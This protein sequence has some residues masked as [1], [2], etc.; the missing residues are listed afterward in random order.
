MTS[1]ERGGEMTPL[2]ELSGRDAVEN[3]L[4]FI[5]DA[6]RFDHLPDVVAERGVTARGIAPSSF[7]ASSLPSILT[8]QYPSTHRVWMFDDRLPERPPLLKTD[9]VDVGFDAQTVWIEL[10]PAE[11]P[12][13]QIHRMSEEIELEALEP[14]FTNVVHD[15]GPHAPYGFENGVFEST[16]AFFKEYSEMDELAALYERDCVTSAERFMERY[17]ELEARGLLEST[18]VVFTS[19]HGQCL[20]EPENGGRFGHGHPLTPAIVDIPI[21][22]MGAGLPKG[23]RLSRVLS[24][25]DIAPTVLSAQGREVPDDVDGTDCWQGVPDA[26]R[27]A[28]SEVWQHLPVGVRDHTVDLSVYGATSAWDDDGGYVFLEKSTFERVLALAYD[29]FFRGYAPAYRRNL[30]ARAAMNMLRLAAT[31]T[32]EYGEPSFSEA[33]ARAVVPESLEPRDDD[34]ATTLSDEQESHLRDLGYIQ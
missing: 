28:R 29:N 33:R 2:T 11:K 1:Y 16:R 19:D 5:S 26:D 10:P 15:V 6:M 9:E 22:F 14:P 8:G 12:P 13:L 18:L 25:T 17:R 21:V 32:V 31:G 23:E 30:T 20:G 4:I 3:V 34:S 24:S 7:T 27:L